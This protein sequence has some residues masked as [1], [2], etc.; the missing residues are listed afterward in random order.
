MEA[1]HVADDGVTPSEVVV[2]S[3]VNNVGVTL[4]R[5]SHLILLHV[6]WS[7]FE[8][9]QTIRR[10]YGYPNPY[11]V[12]VWCLVSK[13]STDVPMSIITSTKRFLSHTLLNPQ[14]MTSLESQL[15]EALDLVRKLMGV[16]IPWFNAEEV[17]SDPEEVKKRENDDPKGLL[18]DRQFQTS[19]RVERLD[20]RE[21]IETKSME[22]YRAKDI[23]IQRASVLHTRTIKAEEADI[24]R[25]AKGKKVQRDKHEAERSKDDGTAIYVNEK[26]HKEARTIKEKKEEKREMRRKREELRSYRV[27]KRLED[28]GKRL[29]ARMTS[30][31]TFAERSQHR[32]EQQFSQAAVDSTRPASSPVKPEAQ[33]KRKLPIPLPIAKELKPD[34]K[35]PANPDTEPPEGRKRKNNSRRRPKPKDSNEEDEEME[36]HSTSSSEDSSANPKRLKPSKKSEPSAV[37]GKRASISKDQGLDKKKIVRRQRTSSSSEESSDEETDRMI[38][39]FSKQNNDTND[40]DLPPIQRPGSP[41]A[42]KPELPPTEQ[43]ELPPSRQRRIQRRRPSEEEDDDEQSS[44]HDRALLDDEAKESDTNMA[45]RSPSSGPK[46]CHAFARHEEPT[47]SQSSFQLFQEDLDDDFNPEDGLPSDEEYARRREEQLDECLDKMNVESESES[48]PTDDSEE[49]ESNSRNEGEDMDSVMEVDERQVMTVDNDRESIGSQEDGMETRLR[50]EDN[51]RIRANEAQEPESHSAK[52]EMNQGRGASPPLRRQL[53]S[54]AI[55][56]I[57]PV[58][59]VLILKHSIFISTSNLTPPI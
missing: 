25:E 38:A 39:E 23:E 30:Y 34:E 8:M 31:Q 4:H 50:D 18:G 14:D 49:S 59:V 45:G 42:Q 54:R 57:S 15:P 1:P 46:A 51:A 47:S 41:A 40:T 37:K 12:T 17:D 28:S 55:V 56:D 2:S 21:A 13:G 29:E 58:T 27:E 36:Q 6:Q 7:A 16:Q 24:Q 22:K 44:A 43:P 5:C 33:M 35:W 53:R 11:H 20:E 10:V 3:P 9:E 52:E 19:K 32:V 26:R 48:S